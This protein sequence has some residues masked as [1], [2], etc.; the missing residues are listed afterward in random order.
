MLKRWLALAGLV[1]VLDQ[2]SKL[3]IAS[4]F[5]YGFELNFGRRA[6]QLNRP[7]RLWLRRRFFIVSLGC[8]YLSS[9]QRGGLGDYVRRSVVDLGKFH[10]EKTCN[11]C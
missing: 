10:G 4:H 3:Y 9:F 5:V 6:G 1:I 8:A 11:Y 7:D 2:C